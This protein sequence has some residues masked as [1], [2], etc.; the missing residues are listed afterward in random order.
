MPAVNPFT[1]Y[2]VSLFCLALSALAPQTARAKTSYV[3]PS[4]LPSLDG[5]P[6][7]VQWIHGATLIVKDNRGADLLAFFKGS[8]DLHAAVSSDN[9]SSWRWVNASSGAKVDP[10][11][12]IAQSA[13]GQIHIMSWS[14]GRGGPFYSRLNL[15]RDAAGHLSDFSVATSNVLF[16]NNI[17]FGDM[18]GDLVAGSDGAGN[19]T[20]FF[21]IYEDHG[22]GGRVL[23]GKT[24]VAA[25]VSPTAISQFVGLDGRSSL[26]QLD[27]SSDPWASPHNAA[28]FMA[29]HPV[30][31]DVWFQWG[32]LNTG[33]GLTSNKLP[34]RRA[35]AVANDST[36]SVGPITNV[37]VFS[38]G[39][40]TQNYAAVASTNYVWFMYG[41][42]ASAI[43]ID[44][45]GA[46]GVVSSNVV[47]SPYNAKRSGGFFTLGVNAAETK[48]WVAGQ[49]AEDGE[50]PRPMS[51]WAKHWD[52]SKW[53]TYS[54]AGVRDELFRICRS[55]GWG[56]GLAFVQSRFD[57]SSWRPALGVIRTAE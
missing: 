37:A 5:T 29:Q 4:Y 10:P 47:P 56:E 25:G 40:G 13:D 54:A 41:S 1:T 22:S 49:V 36:Y 15:T 14:Y 3:A 24:T 35:R 50:D 46:N 28:V 20:L 12:A 44:R 32:P 45:A 42:S 31:R 6:T 9:G 43:N 38:G 39:Y 18:S 11:L 23:A 2:S 8:H 7:T 33:D 19:P 34:L 53:S 30:S 57:Y 48:L 21:A 26:T 27:A 52:G 55:S 17:N 51:R 16:A